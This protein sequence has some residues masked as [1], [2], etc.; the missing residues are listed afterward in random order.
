MKILAVYD[1]S[2]DRL[3][4]KIHRKLKKY[5][6]NVQYSC[7]EIEVDEEDLGELENFVKKLETE[8]DE[9]D[10]VYFYPV[11]GFTPGKSKKVGDMDTLI[12]KGGELF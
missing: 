9:L 7:F 11:K 6:L 4:S 10:K 1:I 2:D 12:V 3:R 8:F 5:G